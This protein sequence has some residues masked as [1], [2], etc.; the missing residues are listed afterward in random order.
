[1]LRI[2]NTL[3]AGSRRGHEVCEQKSAVFEYKRQIWNESREG[4]SLSLPSEN[5]D[6]G[7]KG[8]HLQGFAPV[9]D[10]TQQHGQGR[11][12]VLLECDEVD[13]AE[14]VDGLRKLDNEISEVAHQ[15]LAI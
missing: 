1:M 15:P 13:G 11:V 7:S 10:E 4:A 6:Q 5:V 8:G 3:L 2:A 12:K 14:V 9:S